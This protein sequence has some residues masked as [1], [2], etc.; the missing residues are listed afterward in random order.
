MSSNFYPP[1]DPN[2]YPY[3]PPSNPNDPNAYRQNTAYPNQGTPPPPDPNNPNPYASPTVAIPAP[4]PGSN[5]Y[6]PPPGSVPSNPNNQL[7]L[8]NPGPY[9]NPSPPP[10]PPQ[11]ST[12]YGGGYGPASLPPSPPP[13]QR[14][15]G[16]SPAL[17]LLIVMIALVII[18]GGIGLYAF[19]S[20]QNTQKSNANATATAQG[21]S[22]NNA[23][24]TATSRMATATQT[25]NNVNATSTAAANNT[26]ATAT[27]QAVASATATAGIPSQNPYPPNTGTLAYSSSLTTNDGDLPNSGNCLFKGDGYHVT[28]TTGVYTTCPGTG[29]YSN[30]AAEVQM[31]IASG[32]CGGLMVRA[33]AA[34]G[35]YYVFGVCS[36]GSYYISR[37]HGTGASDFDM[38]K[39]FTMSP[40]IQAGN[41][42]SN[43]IAV[44]ANGPNL[45][46]YV[47]HQQVD[48]VNDT[49]YVRGVI[50]LISNANNNSANLV[51][52]I[53]TNARAWTF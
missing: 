25:I 11:P 49:T 26:N 14:H 2:Q 24:S 18:I 32:G 50:G 1:N 38:L 51:E 29:S 5:P 37:Y 40:S 42:Q 7:Y 33:D 35:K 34:A 16:T 20:Y 36:N 10:L 45:D 12:M 4:Q 43:T 46:F 47:N 19:L 23:T 22:A 44:V 28:A 17:R 21:L 3:G 30:F 27:A 8:R 41:S 48:H 15:E 52:V 13:Q 31:Q 9:A 6:G 53:Y 39:D